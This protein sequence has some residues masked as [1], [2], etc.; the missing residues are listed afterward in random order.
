MIKNFIITGIALGLASSWLVGCAS[1]DSP[2]KP[3]EPSTDSAAVEK[4][5][6]RA[7]S[8]FYCEKLTWPQSIDEVNEFEVARR[9]DVSFLDEFSQ[10]ALSS[11]R[12]ILLTVSYV[13]TSGVARKVS[14]IAPPRC[15]G[16]SEDSADKSAV[17][18]AGG[19]IQFRLPKGFALMKGSAIKERWKAPPYPDA[20]WSSDDGTV[21]AIRFGDLELDDSQVGESLQDM[22][23][24]YEAVVP[25]LVW[26]GKESGL[27]GEKHLLRHE[28]ESSSS[29]GPI[30]NVVFS[31]SFAGKLFAITITGPIDR[32]QSISQVAQSVKSSLVVR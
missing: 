2:R 6:F 21:V 32:E 22:V 16:L 3:L 5:L 20:A 28:F 30:L 27:F 25:G 7:V 23:E 15:G 19:G 26:R 31:A 24:A 17:S 10:A 13:S 4:T 12:A 8:D 29:A 18:I 14:F 11:P 1:V 9:G